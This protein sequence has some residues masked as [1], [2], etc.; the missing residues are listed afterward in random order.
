M[1]LFRLLC[2][3]VVGFVLI[4]NSF[5]QNSVLSEG[6]WYKI[7]VTQPGIHKIDFNFLQKSGIDLNAAN[8]KNIRL[9]GNGGGMLPQANHT[10]RHNDL[11]ENAIYVEGENDN[12]FDNGDYILFY[13]QSP[14]SIYYD[15]AQKIYKHQTN[16]YSDTTFYFIT[17]GNTPGLRVTAQANIT[18]ASHTI[19]SFDDYLF[20]EKDLTSQIGS[21]REW[22]GEKFDFTTSHTIDFTIAGIIPDSEIKVTSAVMALASVPTQFILKLN[23]QSLGSQQ[24]PGV[25]SDTYNVKG[26]NK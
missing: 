9:Y 1:L 23:E 2:C 11:A 17:V 14:H 26:V 5:A 20:H 13:A 15:A 25:T 3:L 16:L 24:L 12:K 18:G 7:G 10:F 19:Q 8:P 4:N 22:Y 21:G 6:E